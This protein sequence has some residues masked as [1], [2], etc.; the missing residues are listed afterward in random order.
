MATPVD[1][2]RPVTITH[3]AQLGQASVKVTTDNHLQVE[4]Q[5]DELI[6]RL[7]P[8]GSVAAHCSG[9]NGCMGCS[10]FNDVL[11]PGAVIAEKQ[12]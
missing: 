3:A 12:G 4:F 1:P 7:I 9:C 8:A 5:I 10:M 6:Q 2:K 11:A